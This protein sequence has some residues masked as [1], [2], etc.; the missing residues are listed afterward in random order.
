MIVYS[1][2]PL[3]FLKSLN[4]ETLTIM[5]L[6]WDLISDVLVTGI[7]LYYFKESLSNTKLYGVILSVISIILM[8]F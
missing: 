1:F 8:N 2:Q 3:I 7:G 6:S 5:N 4:S